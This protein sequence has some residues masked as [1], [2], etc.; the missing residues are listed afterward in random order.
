MG[1]G[2]GR[3]VLGR[4]LGREMVVAGGRAVETDHKGRDFKSRVYKKGGRMRLEHAGH[5]GKAAG[6]LIS[7]ICLPDIPGGG[8]GAESNY[9]VF[10]ATKPMTQEQKAK[11]A[12]TGG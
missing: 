2:L 4:I 5:V 12:T 9:A 1:G 8:G 10:H 7:A 6:P 3:V 11:S